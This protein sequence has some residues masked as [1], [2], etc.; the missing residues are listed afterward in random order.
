MYTFS[1]QKGDGRLR[2]RFCRG[3]AVKLCTRNESLFTS[4]G[5]PLWLH[6]VA[7]TRALGVVHSAPHSPYPYNMHG[8]RDFS[9]IGNQCLRDPPWG[10]IWSLSNTCQVTDGI[11]IVMSPFLPE[12][13]RALKGERRTQV[14]D[15]L[16]IQRLEHLTLR[17][18]AL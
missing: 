16:C 13:G 7:G 17:S 14:C 11:W 8:A 1:A 12:S 2:M 15:F 5:L 3:R 10:R 4:F 9:E 6:V 18:S